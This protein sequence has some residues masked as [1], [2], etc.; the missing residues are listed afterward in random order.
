ML[1]VVSNYYNPSNNQLKINNFKKF[2]EGVKNFPLFVAEAAFE[3][4]SFT[5][6]DAIH[7][8]CNSIL[9]QQYRLINHVIK[10]LPDQYDKAVWVDADIIFNDPDWYDKMNQYLD[11]Y[12]MVQSFSE[13]EL[14]DKKM[15]TQIRKNSV[16]KVALENSKL[17]HNVKS[18]SYL[19][20]SSIN[21][22][23]FSWGIQR[24]VIENYGL[25]NHWITGSDDIAFIIAIWGDW[26]NSFFNRMN[27]KT[28]EHYFDWAIPFNDHIKL[29][30]G[31]LDGSICHLWHGQRN[32]KKRWKCLNNYNP[33]ED[34]VVSESGSLEWC[35]DKPDLHQCCRNMCLYYDSEFKLMI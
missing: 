2:K 8:R 18:S 30:V 22:T 4:H 6:N 15:N 11:K 10:N 31:C 9:W 17:P 26:N 20:L 19:D 34:V 32:Y 13:V 3:D 12:K 24:E 5:L 7:V 14:L 33:Y 28:K 16:A 21:A 23:G 1:A 29:N 27:N 35:T 25:Y